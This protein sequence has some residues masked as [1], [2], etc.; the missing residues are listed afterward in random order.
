MARQVKMGQSRTLSAYDVYNQSQTDRSFY[1]GI[2]STPRFGKTKDHPQLLFGS[3]V[4]II[5]LHS[6]FSQD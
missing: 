3:E 2:L 5:N 4:T 6:I 1:Q